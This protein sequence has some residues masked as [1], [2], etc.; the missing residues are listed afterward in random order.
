[1]G[2]NN[3][4]K[5]SVRFWV[6][7]GFW[8]NEN[9]DAGWHYINTESKLQATIFKSY[10]DALDAASTSEL[11]EF[12]IIEYSQTDRKSVK[13]PDLVIKDMQTEK[14]KEPEW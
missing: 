2:K 5:K 12:E 13:K 4:D 14:V 1:M 6:V 3:T 8:E 7:K 9:P 11:S 10:N